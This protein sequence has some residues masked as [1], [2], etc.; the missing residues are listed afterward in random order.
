M[1]M[2]SCSGSALRL[3]FGLVLLVIRHLTVF[4]LTSALQLECG[5]ATDDSQWCTPQSFRNW[6]V[7]AAVNSGP[8]SVTHLSGILNVVN[9]LRKKLIRPWEPSVAHLMMGKFE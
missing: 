6:H 2:A 8:P 3:P 7:A 5:K 4:T 1:W 9:M